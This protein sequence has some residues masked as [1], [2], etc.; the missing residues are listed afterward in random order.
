MLAIT[1]C[2]LRRVDTK[3]SPPWLNEKILSCL[4]PGRGTLSNSAKNYQGG[5]N[6][7]MES[8]KWRRKIKDNLKKLGTYDAAY[9]SVIN[10]L[11]DTLEQRDKVY[12]NYKKNDE[13]MI[14]EYTNKAGKTNMVTNPKIVL[15]NELNKTALS[16]WKELGLTPS[17]LKK[18]G[19]A[20]PE[21][22]PTGLAAALA[23]IE[24]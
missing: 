17:S 7:K 14:V 19:G 9:N 13:D 11:A 4:G 22:K 23:S 3:D 8:E 5:G 2:T 12:G 18:I 21:E 10:T 15:W 6:A 1:R 16:Y 24:S 20:R